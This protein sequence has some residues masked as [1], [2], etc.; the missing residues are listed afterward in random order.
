LPSAERKIL[1]NPKEAT[2]KQSIARGLFLSL[3]LAAPL[4]AQPTPQ[5]PADFGEK[6]NILQI[7]ASAFRP[8]CSA[9]GYDYSQ[10]GFIFAT[11]NP[12]SGTAAEV[13]WAP[14]TLP[15]GARIRFLDLYYNDLD[16]ANDIWVVLRAFGDG[17]EF[18]NLAI[19]TSTG[20]AGV[21]YASSPL[22]DYTVN[23]DLRYDT[24]GRQLVV[25]VTIPN[26]TSSRQFQGADIWWVRQV[27]PAPLSA[28]FND[29]PTNHPFFQ[30]IE[31]LA[32]SG[33]TG[34]CSAAPP[35]Y[36]PDNPVTRG[37]MA[38][39]LAKALGLSWFDQSGLE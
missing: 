3:A 16:A 36:C 2:L 14:V 28:T 31:A 35:L 24:E 5:S 9:L 6:I 15:T 18:E 37:Q 38:V 20:S 22:F 13:M 12:C 25:V 8:R 1:L 29:V 34:G 23:N 7:P 21:G 39:F 33:I 11:N 4:A 27:S 26:A 17:G 32:K 10:L 30:F 19:A